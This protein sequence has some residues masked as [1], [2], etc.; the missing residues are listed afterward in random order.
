M[1]GM[2]TYFWVALGSAIGGAARYWCSGVIAERYGAFF[3]WHTL[4][5][6]VVGSL[7]IGFF[8]T[9]T[10]ADGRLFVS[11]DVRQFVAF[12]LCG[13]FT[14]FST[15]SAQTLA[16]VQDGEW[17]YA[18]GNVLLSVTLCLVAVWLGHVVALELNQLPRT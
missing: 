5:V 7:V 2:T 14:T 16:L 6:N 13:G 9:L 17:L 12:G 18:I 11:S 15:F 8:A 1:S 4:F 3:P 10:G